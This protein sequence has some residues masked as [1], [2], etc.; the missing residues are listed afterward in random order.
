MKAAFENVDQYIAMQTEAVKPL[1]VSI[2]K[3]IKETAPEAEES[4][5]YQMPAYK[6]NGPLV[7]FAA[8]KNHIGFYPTG[9]GIKAFQK[10]IESYKNS[11]GAVQFPLNQPIPHHLIRKM[12][13][14]KVDENLNRIK[15]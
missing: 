7:Y 2:R 3:T 1:L 10:E 9:S 8:Y 14:Y 13:L 5:S 4:I 11:K 12:V 15:K 6:L